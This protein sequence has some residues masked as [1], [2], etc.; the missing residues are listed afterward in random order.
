MASFLSQFSPSNLWQQVLA[1]K[2]LYAPKVNLIPGDVAKTTTGTSASQYYPSIN[3]TINNPPPQ[4][5]GGGGGGGGGAGSGSITPSSWSSSSGGSNYV[6]STN[7]QPDYGQINQQAND[8]GAIIDQEYNN[9]MGALANQESALKSQADL[10]NAQIAGESGK[11]QTQLG[12]EQTTNEQGVQTKLSQAET[13]GK[14]ALQQARDL[15]KQVQQSN[16]AQ[17]SGLG[18]SSSSV[19]EALAETL[20]IETARRIAGVSG[21]LDEIRLNATNELGR[22]KNYFSEKLTNLKNDEAQRKAEIQNSLMQGINQINAARNTAATAKAQQRMELFTNAQNAISNLTQQY[23]QF[24]QS[25]Q[26][27][28]TQKTSALNPIATDPNYLLKFAQGFNTLQSAPGINQFNLSGT[29][30]TSQSGNPYSSYT[31]AGKKNP[32]DP[33]LQ[34]DQYNQWEQQNG[35]GGNL[36][37]PNF[38][39]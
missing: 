5:G 30:G 1:A 6:P 20:G 29:V 7:S 39:D 8:F 26:Q 9:T 33:N 2:A 35:G 3:P 34:P 19:S 28:A 11:V 15:F 22:I 38:T 13:Q 12:Q 31:L 23:Q 16:I 4:G 18:I 24:Q 10:S 27:W 25:L 14:T 37:T 32:Y 36:M 21:S 17:L